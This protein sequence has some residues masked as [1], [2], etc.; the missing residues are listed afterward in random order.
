MT[1]LHRSPPMIQRKTDLGIVNESQLLRFGIKHL[2]SLYFPLVWRQWFQRKVQGSVGPGREGA[3]NSST[4]TA[5][6][7]EY[8]WARHR[9]RSRENSR[10]CWHQ[11]ARARATVLAL[12]SGESRD[13]G[14]RILD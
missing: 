13:I 8:G 14:K 2:R 12:P 9:R 10:S 3:S 11:T 7:P 4:R 6:A 1:N 5:V